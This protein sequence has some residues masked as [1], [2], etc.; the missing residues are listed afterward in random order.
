[1]NRPLFRCMYFCLVM[2]SAIAVCA[3]AAGAQDKSG[4]RVLGIMPV[5]D[6]SGEEYGQQ[7]AHNLTAM[8]FHKLDGAPFDVVLL[9]PGGLYNPLIPESLVDYAQSAEV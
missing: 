4:R 1:M 6:S 2:L 8:E 7:F 5:F 9:N 3:S